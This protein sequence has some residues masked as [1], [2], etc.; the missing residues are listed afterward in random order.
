MATVLTTTSADA[1]GAEFSPSGEF[2][3]QVISALPGIPVIIDVEAAVDN[4]ASFSLL[5]SW[6][7]NE[8]AIKRLAAQYRVRV[9]V[10]GNN[11]GN[12]ITVRRSE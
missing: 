7:L 4:D 3:L 6:R 1:L 10:R 5:Y 9:S 11:P 8:G 2:R 12:L